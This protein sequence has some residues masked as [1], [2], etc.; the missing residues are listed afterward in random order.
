MKIKP[1]PLKRIE[2][3]LNQ[4]LRPELAQTWDNVGLLAGDPNRSV[5]RVLLCIDLMPAVCREA[6]AR[7]AQLVLAYHP[8][9]FEPLK[10]VRADR[11]VIYQAIRSDLA[12]YAIHTALDVLPGGT[13]DTLAD[14]VGLADRAPIEPIAPPATSGKSKLVVFVPRK[15]QHLEKVSL[16]IFRAGAGHIGEYSCCSFL[17]SGHGTFMG[18]DKSHPTIGKPGQFETVEEMRM[19]V[20]VE[21][22]RLPAVVRAMRAAHPYEEPAYDVYPLAQATGEDLGLGRVGTLRRPADLKTIADRIRK[23]SGLKHLQLADGGKKKLFRAAVGPGSCGSMLEKLAGK[24]DLFVT[25]EIRH[26]TAL[27]AVHAGT[28][29]ICLGHGNSERIALPALQTRLKQTLPNLDFL[30]SRSDADPLVAV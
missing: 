7:K 9:I 22:T 14:L 13:S 30:L 10:S 29:V 27:A 2:E 4:T 26:H 24:I 6:V 23:H 5:G 15:A 21:N 18:S 17:S 25:G 16:A 20:L 11:H 3:Q 8:P 12:V 28:S 1:L 19:E